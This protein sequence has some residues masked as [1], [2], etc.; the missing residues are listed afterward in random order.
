MRILR[1]VNACERPCGLGCVLVVTGPLVETDRLTSFTCVCCGWETSFL[2]LISST[3]A[4][5]LPVLPALSHLVPLSHLRSFTLCLS[6]SCHLHSLAPRALHLCL[7][8][9]FP[10]FLLLPRVQQQNRSAAPFLPRRW[11]RLQP[12][13]THSS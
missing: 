4:P 9:L 6:L 1:D 2:P 3:S 8:C 11:S 7:L 5:A 13:G 10:N 12:V